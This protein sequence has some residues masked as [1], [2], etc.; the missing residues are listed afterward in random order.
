MVRMRRSLKRR[1]FLVN[2][3]KWQDRH[4]RPPRQI[5]TST[6]VSHGKSGVHPR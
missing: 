4:S 1:W 2:I 3:H 6:H 5:A